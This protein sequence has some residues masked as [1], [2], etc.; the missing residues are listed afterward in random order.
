MGVRRGPAGIQG[1]FQGWYKG[2]PRDPKEFQMEVQEESKGGIV[3]G[4]KINCRIGIFII[5]L[6]Y[7][8]AHC[9]Y[10]INIPQLCKKIKIPYFKHIV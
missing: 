5:I 4:P 10:R 3:Q 8:N 7:C 6:L 2:G 1:E 9:F